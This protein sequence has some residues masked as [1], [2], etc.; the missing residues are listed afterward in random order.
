VRVPILMYV[1]AALVA[2]GYLLAPFIRF[3]LSRNYQFLADAEAVLITR[4]PKGLAKAL[5]HISED[6]RI[7]VLDRT[8]LL[9]VLCVANPQAHQTFFNRISGLFQSHPPIEERICALNDMDGLFM[10]IRSKK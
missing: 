3:A 9:G 5:W 7:E 10:H 8:E 1:G 6:S 2:Y 4:Y